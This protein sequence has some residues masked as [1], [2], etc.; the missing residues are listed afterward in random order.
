MVVISI[1]QRL[2]GSNEMSETLLELWNNVLAEE[3]LTGV[4]LAF[5]SGGP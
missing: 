2:L 3:R 1:L 4:V 5:W